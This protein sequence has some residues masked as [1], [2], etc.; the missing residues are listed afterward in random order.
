MLKKILLVLLAGLIIIQFI[1]PAQNVSAIP[2]E[3][4]IRLH[5]A[6]PSDVLSIL[7]R[8][9]YDCHSNNTNYPWYAQIQPLGWWLADHIEEGKDELNFSEFA[10]YSPKKADHK[11][12]ETVEMVLEGE[13]PLESYTLVHKDAVLTK[14]EQDILVDWAQN[15]RKTIRSQQ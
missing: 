10:T 12:E 6:V 15:L 2:S 14:N 4:D 5:Y 3:N 13:M 11:L 1:R 7:K 9:C 8:A